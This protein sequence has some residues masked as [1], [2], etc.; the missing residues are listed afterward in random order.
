MPGTPQ[1]TPRSLARGLLSASPQDY[2][3]RPNNGANFASAKNLFSSFGKEVAG[4]FD[5]ADKRAAVARGTKK[6]R[7]M[8][9]R[10]LPRKRATAPGL[11]ARP[12]YNNRA[13]A[14]KHSSAAYDFLVIPIA[15]V[16]NSMTNMLSHQEMLR[17][18]L[19]VKFVSS[20]MAG[21]VIYVS[22]EWL[23][24]SHPDPHGTHFQALQ[25]IL[26]R[27]RDGEIRRVEHTVMPTLS[28]SC[29]MEYVTGKEWEASL[30]SSTFIFVDY[31]CVPQ[32]TAGPMP[33]L[34]WET[35]MG[36]FGIDESSDDLRQVMEFNKFTEGD[37]APRDL[38]MGQGTVK[39]TGC[40]SGTQS[41]SADL[42]DRVMASM[43]TFIEQSDM[44]LVLAPTCSAKRNFQTWRNCG[45]CRLELAC[46]ALARSEP[47]VMV[48]RGD[49][50]TPEFISA[51]DA[52]LVLPV[53][54]APND[55]GF[56]RHANGA[57]FGHYAR[58]VLEKMLDS[59]VLALKEQGLVFEQRYLTCI[60]HHILRGCQAREAPP[61]KA[62]RVGGLVTVGQKNIATKYEGSLVSLR[63]LL[64]WGTG[65]VEAKHATETG[66]TLLHYAAMS[67]HTAAAQELLQSTEWERKLST[68]IEPAVERAHRGHGLCPLALAMAF[69]DA[70]MVGAL[71]QAGA[72]PTQSDQWGLSPFMHACANGR[73]GNARFWLQHFKTWPLEKTSSF[74]ATALDCALLY[75]SGGLMAREIADALLGAGAKGGRALRMAASNASTEPSLICAILKHESVKRGVNAPAKKAELN[76][77]CVPTNRHAA[78]RV[79]RFVSGFAGRTALHFAVV[80][81]NLPAVSALIDVGAADTTKKNSAGRTAEDEAL[82]FYGRASSGALIRK[83]GSPP[84]RPDPAL[85][86]GGVGVVE[87]IDTS[88]GVPKNEKKWDKAWGGENENEREKK[89]EQWSMTPVKEVRSGLQPG[90]KAAAQLRS[91]LVP[92]ELRG[93]AATKTSSPTST[94]GSAGT[95]PA[96]VVVPLVALPKTAG[97]GWRQA[98]LEVEEEDWDSITVT[99]L[100]E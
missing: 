68:C 48:V 28:R 94:S 40:P 35:P 66:A 19:L 13:C 85:L 100:T 78:G 74:G 56:G 2:G 24:D 47:R 91:P 98:E 89:R 79:V 88:E 36:V 72:T 99:E 11:T 25:G 76:L 58:G 43:P 22:H 46:A 26:T 90:K 18:G 17:A 45:W 71:L 3:W 80:A 92:D 81:G 44:M 51:R 29:E 53:G 49:T 62:Q 73:V 37:M 67:N 27:L 63:A 77:L 1:G 42:M 93:A 52:L 21:R 16:L 33:A 61:A 59:K 39:K 8:W 96:N 4:I 64:G 20:K 31:C 75:G 5:G 69:S 87:Y 12:V 95:P 23:G 82:D 60:R 70:K 57:G 84:P 55:H 83:L 54:Q 30:S 7:A 41:Y 34:I 15:T 10:L 6:P 38:G 14:D 97:A 32:P 9:R 86:R 65:A 50:A